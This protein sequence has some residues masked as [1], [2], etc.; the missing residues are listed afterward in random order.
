[1]KGTRS[2]LPKKNI[3]IIIFPKTIKSKIQSHMRKKTDSSLKCKKKLE[4][5]HDTTV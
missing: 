1:M 2:F 3:K 5:K 4:L